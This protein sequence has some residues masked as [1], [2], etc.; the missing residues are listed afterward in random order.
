M[1]NNILKNKIINLLYVTAVMLFFGLTVQA[2]TLPYEIANN[3]I[4][5]DHE[6]FV[7]IVG[8]TDGHV[9]V[10]ATTGQVNNMNTSNNTV[11]GPV[12]NGNKGPGE[13]GK[14]ANCFRRLSDIPNKTINI[15]KIAGCRILISFKSQLYL[16]FFG[17]S[18]SPS[19]YSA[20]NLANPTDPNQGI[21]FELIELTYNDGG[22]WC[23]TSRVDSYQYP[24]GLEIWGD[25]FYKKVGEL[26][27]HENIISQWQETAPNEF[28]NLLNTEEGNIHFPTKVETFPKDFMDDYINDIWSKYSTQ[29]L[30]FTS[31][32]GIWRGSVQDE[33]QF[34]FKRDSD[35]QI[36]RIPGKPT[37]IQAMEGSGVMASGERWDKVVQSQMVAAITRHALDVNVPSGVLQNFGDTSKYYQIWPYNW[38]SKF[39]HQT[40]ISFESQTYTFAYDDVYN[41]SA[42]IHTPKPL[43]IKI[44]LGGLEA[45]SDPN[46]TLDHV[47]LYWD[48]SFA[49]KSAALS[50]GRY[51]MAQLAVLGV[52]NDHVSSLRIQPGYQATL[53]W[54]DNFSGA[55]LVKT[56]DVDCLTNDGNWNDKMTSIIISKTSQ[57]GSEQKIEAEHYTSMHGITTEDCAE[58]G[59]NVGYIDTADWMAYA[60]INFSSSGNYRIEYR[61][62]SALEGGALSADL[63][64][65]T[66]VLG[67]IN[68]PNTG[69]WQNWT[70]LAH[71][72]YINA[73][74]HALGLY[75]TNGGWNINW[76]KITKL[77]SLKSAN[78]LLDNNNEVNKKTIETNKTKF[79]PNPFKNVLH[80]NFEEKSAQITVLNTQGQIV[81]APLTVESGKPVDFS[82]LSN[83]LYLIN[84]EKNGVIEN[85]RVVKE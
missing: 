26:K 70:T 15:P 78:I 82:K 33:N 76:I 19:G 29:E 41:Q 11:S 5:P 28:K 31:D 8:I 10:D 81:L 40:D 35:G 4:Y 30:V 65:G 67:Q 36:A 72:V 23:N 83:G 18:G 21:K 75:A 58:G 71:T 43:N 1:K 50:E 61:V 9:W 14:Y 64:A 53:Y 73:G 79:Y 63:N 62:A 46:P 34:V 27:S 17:H 56:S 20:P 22:L 16:Y 52:P 49:G 57:S 42:T 7:A 32:A 80:F 54:D 24:M 3:S 85:I 48:C 2:Q 59:Q 66:T 74:T 69:G 38:Y 13:N 44:T 6:V 47:T 25:G 37:T 68:I 12:I 77:S 55:D 39:F 60:N 84:I 51:T 45:S